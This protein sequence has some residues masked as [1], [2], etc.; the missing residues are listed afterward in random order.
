MGI[1]LDLQASAIEAAGGYRQVSR[2]LAEESTGR[3]VGPLE[4]LT[5]KWVEKPTRPNGT[6]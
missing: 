4:L 5:Q 6:N 2:T 1:G 3:H